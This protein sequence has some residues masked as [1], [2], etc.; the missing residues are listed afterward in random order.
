MK[1]LK[2]K[3]E[4]P[5]FRQLKGKDLYGL[6]FSDSTKA[7]HIMCVL[8]S[9]STGMSIEKVEQLDINQYTYYAN[10]IAEMINKRPTP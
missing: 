5:I 7:A 1:L 2:F 4:K 9:K 10:K 3:I 8:I 6:D